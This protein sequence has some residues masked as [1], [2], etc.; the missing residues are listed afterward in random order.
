[1]APTNLHPALQ[2]SK[3]ELIQNSLDGRD[4][5][6]ADF[7]ADDE[8]HDDGDDDDDDHATGVG[9]WRRRTCTQRC[10]ARKWS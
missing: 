9:V 4:D 8:A 2:S 10:K 7:D 6:H 5:D 3:V 1:V